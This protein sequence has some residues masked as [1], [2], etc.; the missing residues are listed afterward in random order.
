MRRLGRRRLESV[1]FAVGLMTFNDVAPALV[2]RNKKAGTSHWVN[3][4]GSTLDRH[5]KKTET[6]NG[7]HQ[8]LGQR[9]ANRQKYVGPTLLHTLGRRLPNS[10][11]LSV[12]RASASIWF[13]E[14]PSW[15]ILATPVK[16]GEQ[17]FFTYCQVYNVICHELGIFSK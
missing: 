17:L 13:G 10:R 15:E 2:W 12:P 14:K 8:T 5:I 16:F 9:D 6:G 1:T 7:R 4:V 11:F 3:G